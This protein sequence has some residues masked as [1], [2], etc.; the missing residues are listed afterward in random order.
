MEPYP[1]KDMIKPPD[2]I[3]VS[4]AGNLGALSN[5]IKAISSYVDVLMSGYSNA[6]YVSPLGNKY[7]M[8]TNTKCND[9]G[10]V[11]HDRYVFVNNI[12]DKAFGGQGLVG[13]IAQSL[14]GMDPAGLFKAFSS[15]ADTCQSITMDTRDNNNTVKQESRYVNTA[16]ISTYN[17]CW[18]PDKRNPISGAPCREG[19]EN[20]K[21]PK[22]PIV[23]LYVVG[24]GCVAGYMVY[25]FLKK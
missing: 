7:F 21:V 2:Q 25:R 11:V 1:Y 19:F 3:G 10:G 24:I 14:G 6:Q 12:P 9:K 20:Q 5:D 22:D 17:A 18:F 23:Q 15:K 4:D 8:P 16:D 13:G